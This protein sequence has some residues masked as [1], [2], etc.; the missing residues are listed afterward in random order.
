MF[1][2]WDEATSSACGFNDVEIASAGGRQ[3]IYSRWIP[4][5]AKLIHRFTH[6]PLR[7]FLPPWGTNTFLNLNLFPSSSPSLSTT[8]NRN[9][10]HHQNH[11]LHINPNV[12]TTGHRQ[13]IF[14]SS[15]PHLQD[16]HLLRIT[17]NEG[18][19]QSHHP[20]PRHHDGRPGLCGPR[21]GCRYLDRRRC[22]H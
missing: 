15:N 19:H 6:L 16:Q 3:T 21:P 17:E 9:G 14:S 18:R 10:K 1:T 13:S 12:Q 7:C 4:V 11:L 22:R 2:R 5:M 8:K 20:H